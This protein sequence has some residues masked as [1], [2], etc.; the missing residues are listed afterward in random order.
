MAFKAPKPKEPEPPHLTVAGVLVPDTGLRPLGGFQNTQ[1]MNS[2]RG[3][4]KA[5]NWKLPTPGSDGQ[6]G[7][8]ES[9]Q[10]KPIGYGR[11]RVKR[12]QE[13]YDSGEEAVEEGP[14]SLLGD[15]EFV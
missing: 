2:G 3:R 10:I 11:D 15:E 14:A 1:P 13:K 12:N 4:D 9:E 7:Q 5:N 8:P 6:E